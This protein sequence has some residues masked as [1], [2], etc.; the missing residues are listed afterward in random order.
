MG[1]LEIFSI[2]IKELREKMGMTQKE[3]S[4]HIGIRQQTLS[5]YERGVMKPPLDVAKNIAEKCNV[6]LDWLCGLPEKN[7][8]DE[9]KSY[10]DLFCLLIKV[11]DV[12]PN[13]WVVK[14]EYPGLEEDLPLEVQQFWATLK[15]T[16][17]VIFKF[18]CDWEKMYKLYSDGT[19][20][21]HLYHLWIDDKL[22]SYENMRIVPLKEDVELPFD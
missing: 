8:F 10:K 20:D 6:S 22:K 1:E 14:T 3:F 17:D 18:F 5:G 19:I 7:Y 15:T 11:T 16:D 12:L 21:K 9:I 13:L 4:E 2:R